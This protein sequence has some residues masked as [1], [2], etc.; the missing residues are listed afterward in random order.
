MTTTFAFGDFEI[1]WVASIPFHFNSWGVIVLVIIF[2]NSEIPFASISF[3]SASFLALSILISYSNDS[4]SCFNF[5]SIAVLSV[6]GR[7][8]SLIN[9]A[10]K[11][12]YL[13]WTLAL[14]RSSISSSIASLFVEYSSSGR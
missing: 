5:C 4:C 8:T 9:I 13:D 10:S 1:S 14:V 6:W 2:W 3:L 11:V 7:V 12:K